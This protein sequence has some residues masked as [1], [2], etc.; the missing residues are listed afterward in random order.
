MPFMKGKKI[1]ADL[2]FH[3]EFEFLIFITKR[4]GCCRPGVTGK[5]FTETFRKL[6]K[7]G[8]PVDV[9]Y[10][11]ARTDPVTSHLFSRYNRFDCSLLYII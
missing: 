1:L 10:E 8:N 3:P 11:Y 4:K 7:N 5:D 9:Y 2:I 6:D